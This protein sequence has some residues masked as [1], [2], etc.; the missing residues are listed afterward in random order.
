[1]KGFIEVEEQ[2]YDSLKYEWIDCKEKASLNISYIRKIVGHRIY[3]WSSE[4]PTYTKHSYEEIKAK[5]KEAQ[6]DF[7]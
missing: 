4:Y 3:S 7:R 5:I 1:M 6:E 2:Y